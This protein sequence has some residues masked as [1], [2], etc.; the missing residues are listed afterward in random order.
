MA[1]QV[2]DGI[3]RDDSAGGPRQFL[4][5]A[6]R[7]AL[8]A[9]GLGVAAGGRTDDEFALRLRQLLLREPGLSAQRLLTLPAARAAVAA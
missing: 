3:V 4:R 7:L 8:P 2:F 1:R 6:G 9:L 5:D